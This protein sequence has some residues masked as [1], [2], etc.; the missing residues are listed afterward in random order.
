MRYRLSDRRA[1]TFVA[2]V[3]AYEVSADG[4]KLVYRAAGGGGG[5]GRGPG[6]GGGPPAPS[7]FIVD[8]DRNP[9][10]AGQ[11]R[12][13]FSLR[14]YLDPREVFKQIFNEGWRNQRDYLYV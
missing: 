5:G 7:L 12:V 3:T 13:T 4:H 14:M 1:A 10:T 9:P 11:G 6:A 2:G 8:A